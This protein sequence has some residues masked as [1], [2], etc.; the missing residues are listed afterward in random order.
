MKNS[1][2]I[3]R[4]EL[5][6]SVR[7]L[8]ELRSIPAGVVDIL[9]FKDPNRGALAAVDPVVWSAAVGVHPTAKLSAALG[10]AGEAVGEPSAERVPPSFA[11]AKAGPA[12]L[13]IDELAACWP[14]V[15]GRLPGGVDFVPAAYADHAAAAAPPPEAIVEA[16]IETGYRAV[17]ID[18]CVKDGRTSVNHLGCER[19]SGLVHRTR[20]AGVRLTLAGS[21]RCSDARRLADDPRLTPDCI[22]IRGAVCDAGR[23]ATLNPRRLADWQPWRFGGCDPGATPADG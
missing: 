7:D 11:F 13:S 9:D 5:L 19:L 15:A 2:K 23:A 21:L 14:A 17:L 16:A 12:G 1:P 6:V 3:D 8:D 20:A 22:G 10:E 4:R 18:T